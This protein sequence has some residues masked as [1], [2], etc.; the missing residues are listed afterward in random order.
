[1]CATGELGSAFVLPTMLDCEVLL[2]W[3]ASEAILCHT[4]GMKNEIEILAS[5]PLPVG[6]ALALPPPPEAEAYTGLEW[7]TDEAWA[8]CL[9]VARHDRALW[10][11]H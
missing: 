9:E 6:P 4:E 1:V 7:L 2:Q 11:S 3:L 8:D 10:A 5:A